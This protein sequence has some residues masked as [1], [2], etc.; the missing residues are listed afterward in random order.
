MICSPDRYETTDML[1]RVIQS[2]VYTEN[3]DSTVLEEYG[4]NKSESYTWLLVIVLLLLLG[5]SLYM[6]RRR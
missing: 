5:V 1:R 6:V 3:F 4:A 2:A